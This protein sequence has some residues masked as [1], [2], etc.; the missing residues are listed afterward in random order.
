[1]DPLETPDPTL[2]LLLYT[3]NPTRKG[4]GED[5]YICLLFRSAVSKKEELTTTPTYRELLCEPDNSSEEVEGIFDALARCFSVGT[6]GAFA[7][8]P[9]NV[10]EYEAHSSHGSISQTPQR[11]NYKRNV[12]KSRKEC[13]K[14]LKSWNG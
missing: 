7:K 13:L 10:K 4:E 3:R 9:K 14:K 2:G 6:G 1:M 12:R 5:D 8:P 11:E